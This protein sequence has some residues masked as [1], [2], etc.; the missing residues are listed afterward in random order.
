MSAIRS[1]AGSTKGKTSTA[2][3]ERDLPHR[4]WQ[5]LQWQR[6]TQ[7]ESEYSS[8]YNNGACPVPPRRGAC[9]LEA[10]RFFMAAMATKV[11]KTRAFDVGTCACSYVD[12]S[13]YETQGGEKKREL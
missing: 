11:I 12:E 2:C 10:F 6:L 8:I 9:G 13:N 1:V 7:R 4:S 3:L 5:A